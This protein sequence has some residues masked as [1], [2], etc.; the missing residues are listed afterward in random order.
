MS[1]EKIKELNDVNLIK[2][3]PMEM[4]VELGRVKMT[5]KDLLKVTQGSI[6][7]LSSSAGELLNIYVNNKLIA[8][9]EVV[10]VNDKFGIRLIEIIRNGNKD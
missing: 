1:D 2:D 8:K 3:I 5:I 4:R 10:L 7:E 6:V 9:G